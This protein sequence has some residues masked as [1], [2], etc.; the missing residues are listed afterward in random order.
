MNSDSRGSFTLAIN[1]ALLYIFSTFEIISHPEFKYSSS[2]YPA[3]MPAFDSIKISWFCLDK[4][5]AF[6]GIIA[7]LFS[8]FFI[9]FGTPI[10]INYYL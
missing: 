8:L 3:P 4:I 9:S 7:T 1:S 10:I 6:S 5:E 2:V